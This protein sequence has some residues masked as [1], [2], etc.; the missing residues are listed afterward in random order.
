ME[1]GNECLTRQKMSRLFFSCLRFWW[2]W[3]A[4][5]GDDN[6]TMN[7]GQLRSP[8]RCVLGGC[9]VR[10]KPSKLKHEPRTQHTTTWGICSR[11]TGRSHAIV[12]CAS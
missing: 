3:A 12:H 7:E 6:I 2:R 8:C 4:D 9:S 5:D 11:G 1:G 10:E